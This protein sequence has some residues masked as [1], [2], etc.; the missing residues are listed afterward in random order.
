[1]LYLK[2]DTEES[3]NTFNSAMNTAKNYPSNGATSYTSCTQGIDGLYY[4]TAFESDAALL[5]G[6]QMV[7]Q[8][9]YEA[10]T[11][12]EEVKEGGAL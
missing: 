4:A 11:V 7:T 9:E 3:F 2:F 6:V 10:V 12:V 1:M 8:E 5:V